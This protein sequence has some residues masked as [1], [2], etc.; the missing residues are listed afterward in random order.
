MS[1]IPSLQSPAG[2][3]EALDAFRDWVAAD[4]AQRA[5]H[6]SLVVSALRPDQVP[7]V[8]ADAS[9]TMLTWAA[10]D[11]G[12]P[13]PTPRCPDGSFDAIYVHRMMRLAAP[14]AWLGELRRALAP[15]G[16]VL[17]AADAVEFAFAPLPSGGDVL[18]MLRALHA[19]GFRRAALV[20]RMPRLLVVAAQRDDP[21]AAH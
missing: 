15:G 14:E 12:A 20:C 6:R 16:I 13:V 17:T 19:A 21:M 8:R 2:D 1:A 4:L 3:V 10:R 9:V 7:P 18:L 5:A 11:G